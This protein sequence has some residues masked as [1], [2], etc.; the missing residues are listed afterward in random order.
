MSLFQSFAIIVSLTALFAYLNAR[1]LK[2]P[3][4]IGVMVVALALSLLLLVLGGGWAQSLAEQLNFSKV[5]LN[6]MLG[7]LLFASALQLD[8]AAL[9]RRGGSVLLLAVISTVVST[10]LVGVLTYYAL[11]PL[12]LE[13]PLVYSLVFGALISPT[14]PVAVSGLLKQAG[15]SDTFKIVITGESLFNDGVGI[16]LFGVF[17]SLLEPQ[18]NVTFTSVAFSLLREAGG[19]IVLGLVL[20]FVAA[21][22]MDTSHDFTVM[23]LLTLAVV[24]GGYA[25]ALLLGLSGP[26]SMAVAG[27]LVGGC[28][29][30]EHEDRYLRSYWEVTDRLLNVA[31]FV[32]IGLE[33]LIVPFGVRTLLAGAVAVPLVLM[34]RL[35]SVRLALI[36]VRLRV[37]L[38]PSV[39]N[40]LTWAALR[41]G[42][43]IA[44]ALA[45]PRGS[46]AK[47]HSRDDL[48]R[49]PLF[50]AGAR[51][52]DRKRRGQKL[53]RRLV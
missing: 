45:L 6:G 37:D 34:A 3:T 46:G 24:T 9:K 38:P 14:D 53:G 12:G 11:K 7:A 22:L 29:L 50:G 15:L 43:A 35:V 36:P 51:S 39:F 5:L 30:G 13:L 20:G 33:L 32:L 49:R 4:P 23:V 42:I 21:R 18:S 17:A 28:R 31:L 2:L 10:F 19:G 52:D 26:V 16:V 27:L 48:R 41:G 40:L 47:P 8:N 44:L 1:F 25:L